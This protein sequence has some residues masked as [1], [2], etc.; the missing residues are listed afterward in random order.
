MIFHDFLINFGYFFLRVITAS[1]EVRSTRGKK[2]A[3]GSYN[4]FDLIS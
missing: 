3:V 1:N 2:A 4:H